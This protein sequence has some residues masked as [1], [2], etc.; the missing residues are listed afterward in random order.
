MSHCLLHIFIA[1]ARWLRPFHPVR[2]TTQNTTEAPRYRLPK[3]NV[4]GR[5]ASPDGSV[6]AFT[7][8][9]VTRRTFFRFE[10]KKH[11][12]TFRVLPHVPLS[13]SPSRVYVNNNNKT[14]RATSHPTYQN[15]QEPEAPC[16]KSG[17]VKNRAL[18]GSGQ[19]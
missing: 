11:A 13:T 10:K 19:T 15:A 7:T 5:K 8:Y 6:Y 9:C 4:H 12:Q 16:Q 2:P 1:L 14:Y 3:K 17:P 18:P